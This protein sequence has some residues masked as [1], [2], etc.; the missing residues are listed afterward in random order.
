MWIYCGDGTVN[1]KLLVKHISLLTAFAFPWDF[2]DSLTIGAI[3]VLMH[4][5]WRILPRPLKGLMIGK[6]EAP[7]LMAGFKQLP[8]VLVLLLV[9]L[10]EYI[11]WGK[12]CLVCW[13]KESIHGVQTR[14]LV[15]WFNRLL[16]KAE[17]SLMML[18]APMNKLTIA[19]RCFSRTQNVPLCFDLSAHEFWI[20]ALCVDAVSIKFNPPDNIWP[21]SHW[22]DSS[23]YEAVTLLS[24]SYMEIANS[25]QGRKK[26]IFM[27]VAS[28]RY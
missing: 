8:L 26:L 10:W 18:W 15:R 4:L 13:L 23:G 27:L 20:I 5:H 2:I 1:E 21:E 22:L 28:F 19:D 6:E 7:M 9:Y 17:S 12:Y 25:R 3:S 14:K 16:G 24:A 11:G